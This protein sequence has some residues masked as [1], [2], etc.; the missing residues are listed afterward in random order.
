LDGA[1]NLIS[2]E[3]QIGR[4][5]VGGDRAVRRRHVDDCDVCT[6]FRRIR[7]VLAIKPTA[8][9]AQVFVAVAPSDQ[10]IDR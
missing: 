7:T 9:E 10:F 2:E 1:E 6:L 8:T 3:G 5:A 4:F